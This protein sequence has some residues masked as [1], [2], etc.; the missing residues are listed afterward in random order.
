MTQKPEKKSKMSQSEHVAATSRGESWCSLC[1]QWRPFD[2]FGQ[3]PARR[4]GCQG[5]C[6]ACA[7]ADSRRRQGR[8]P[9]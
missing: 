7:T 5:Y 8:Q 2:A 4:N 6:K 3:A 9:A 1:A